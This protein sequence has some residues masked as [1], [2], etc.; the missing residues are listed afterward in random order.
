MSRAPRIAHL[1]A[2]LALGAAAAPSG[3]AQEARARVQTRGTQAVI[4]QPALVDVAVLEARALVA[5]PGERR[6][7]VVIGFASTREAS[8]R[9]LQSPPISVVIAVRSLPP[10]TR[11][12]AP[13]RAGD[14]ARLSVGLPAG[15]PRGM[16]E[17]EVRLTP[18]P[19]E[20]NLQ[21][22]VW[23]GEFVVEE[24]QRP[25][26]ALDLLFAGPPRGTSLPTPRV[27]AV[28]RL[29][30]GPVGAG[31]FRG[32]ATEADQLDSARM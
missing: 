22:N 19:G 7:D 29:S 2:W 23:R 5:S 30:S 9:P 31:L 21:N 24:P 4:A 20:R 15:L 16:Y 3:H 13:I 25:V 27:E 1:V 8:A 17:F 6:I 14:R 26:A 28:V 12:V 11:Q 32:A 10:A 18:I